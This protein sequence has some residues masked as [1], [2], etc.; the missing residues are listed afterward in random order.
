MAWY[1]IPFTAFA[2][3][4]DPSFPRGHTAKRPFL[5]V[6]LR[7]GNSR[8]PCYVMVDS[9]ADHCTFPLSFALQ[10]GLDPL[11]KRASATSGVGYEFVPTFYW[12]IRI[13]FPGVREFDVYAGFTSGLDHVGVGLLGQC[14]FFDRVDVVFHHREGT[15]S[16]DM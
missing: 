16:I 15:F 12:P 2:Y 4:P 7:N 14:G 5:R 6:D 3:P 10:L 1:K 9:G 13:E 11:S 8:L